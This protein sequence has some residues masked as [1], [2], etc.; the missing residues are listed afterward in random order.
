MWVF[1]MNNAVFMDRIFLIRWLNNSFKSS[2]MCMYRALDWMESSFHWSSIPLKNVPSAQED[3]NQAWKL[4]RLPIR[5]TSSALSKHNPSKRKNLVKTAPGEFYAFPCLSFTPPL[6]KAN[7]PVNC[8]TPRCAK[9][10]VRLN[11]HQASGHWGGGSHV[12]Q[13]YTHTHTSL[14]YQK[15]HG[16]WAMGGKC[17]HYIPTCYLTV[18]SML[19]PGFKVWCVRLCVLCTFSLDRASHFP[20]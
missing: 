19:S 6:H 17:A 4:R 9:S 2:P 13:T 7:C 15:T 20:L 18:A 5:I 14:Y 10:P 12:K 16:R 11:K 3:W 8:W 1:Q